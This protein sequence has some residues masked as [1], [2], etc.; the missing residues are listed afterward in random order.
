[1]EIIQ[2]PASNTLWTIPLTAGTIIIII[3]AGVFFYNLL[4][5]KVVTDYKKELKFW[6]II[7]L[8]VFYVGFLPVQLMQKYI[9]GLSI[10]YYFVVMLLNF[11]MY[12]SFSIGFLS[13]KK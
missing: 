4:Q 3:L 1:M 12:G 6:I 8:L 10:D 7:G 9:D 11:L 5:S 2:M 13:I